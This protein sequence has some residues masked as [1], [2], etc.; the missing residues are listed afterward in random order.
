MTQYLIECGS[1]T[2]YLLVRDTADSATCPGCMGT[3]EPDPD[4]RHPKMTKII[5]GQQRNTGAQSHGEVR[6]M[7][8]GVKA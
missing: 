4:W 3:L 6:R 2:D 8:K 5:G 7:V 1:C